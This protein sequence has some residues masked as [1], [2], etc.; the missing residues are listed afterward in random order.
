MPMPACSGANAMGLLLGSCAGQTFR[1]DVLCPLGDHDIL[2]SPCPQVL[3]GAQH[4]PND[5]DEITALSFHPCQRRGQREDAG[6]RP[7]AKVCTPATLTRV[8]KDLS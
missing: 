4:V 2:W 1:Q 3:L 8:S 7:F 6:Q 5:V